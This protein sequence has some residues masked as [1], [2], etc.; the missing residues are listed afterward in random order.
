VVVAVFRIAHVRVFPVKSTSAHFPLPV[1]LLPSALAR[2]S[3]RHTGR[4]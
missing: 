3:V 4:W 1:W 2:R